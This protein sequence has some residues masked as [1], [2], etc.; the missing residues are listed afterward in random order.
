MHL[1]PSWEGRQPGK[2]EEKQ[3]CWVT[4]LK[5]LPK[6]E[7]HLQDPQDLYSAQAV[8]SRI[9]TG[10]IPQKRGHP[11]PVT[12]PRAEVDRNREPCSRRRAPGN[13]GSCRHES[14]A[15]G[16][17][18]RQ[19]HPHQ[20]LWTLLTTKNVNFIQ[21]CSNLRAS[22]ALRSLSH[23]ATEPCFQMKIF[24]APSS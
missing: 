17:A 20:L 11:E 22:R 18:H 23:L 9:C 6:A 13:T 19:T 4:L 16:A 7:K 8:T 24:V 15:Q 5:S 10:E 21:R 2:V 3:A 1:V 14:P 12:R